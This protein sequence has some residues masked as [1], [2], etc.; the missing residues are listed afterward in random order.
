M[1]YNNYHN[2]STAYPNQTQWRIR[3]EKLDAA[4]D[5]WTPTVDKKF[6]LGAIAESRDGR[7]WRYCRAGSSAALTKATMNQAEAVTANWVDEPQTV[8][9]GA[10]VAAVGDTS[11]TLLVQTAPT[12]DVWVDGYML[13]NNG[14]GEGEM[15]IIKEHTLTTNPVVQIAD[16]GGFRTATVDATDI[17]ILKNIC[18]GVIVVPAGAGTHTPVGVALTAVTASYYFWA[19]FWGPCPM[20]VDTNGGGAA[21]VAGN[22]CGEPAAAQDDGTVGVVEADGTLV[23]YGTVLWVAEDLEYGLVNLMLP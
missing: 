4:N 17:T 21:M 19:Q 16:V 13:V 10:V 20:L 2:G 11:I 6:P 15:Y 12:A 8:A 9:S 23:I 7:K 22:M 14:T 1:S 3:A 5:I 18:N